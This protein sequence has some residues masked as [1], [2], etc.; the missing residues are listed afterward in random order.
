MTD[1]SRK[2]F[3]VLLSPPPMMKPLG[4]VVYSPLSMYSHQIDTVMTRYSPLIITARQGWD[5]H[6]YLPP[7]L[8]ETQVSTLP[9]N[10][11][12]LGEEDTG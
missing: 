4:A 3:L 10:Q 9:H 1:L 5:R 11:Q 6:A 7:P 12:E 2:G 8:T